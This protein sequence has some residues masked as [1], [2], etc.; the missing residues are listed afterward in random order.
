[1]DVSKREGM[2]LPNNRQLDCD[3]FGLSKLLGS[4]KRKRLRL[5]ST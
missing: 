4:S 3:V 2:A 1:M 5:A